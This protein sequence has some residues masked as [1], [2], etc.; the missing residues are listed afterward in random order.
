MLGSGLQ[1]ILWRIFD[2][3][4]GCLGL[5]FLSMLLLTLLVITLNEFLSALDLRAVSHPMLSIAKVAVTTGRD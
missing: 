5:S 4:I 1:S 3:L 2:Q